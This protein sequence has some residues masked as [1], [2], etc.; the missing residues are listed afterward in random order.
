V[1]I[2]LICGTSETDD[3]ELGTNDFWVFAQHF[4]SFCNYLYNLAKISCHSNAIKSIVCLLMFAHILIYVNCI[5]VL[6]IDNSYHNNTTV[7]IIILCLLLY[8]YC[9][10]L[11]ILY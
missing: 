4:N 7:F 2:K 11:Y 5:F 3:F 10:N 9:I 1:K 8:V 6:L